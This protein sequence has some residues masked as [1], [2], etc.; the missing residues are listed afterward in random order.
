MPEG[1]KHNSSMSVKQSQA[2]MG[3]PGAFQPAHNQQP[4]RLHPDDMH[5]LVDHIS[6]VAS[7]TYFQ[8]KLIQP[9]WRQLVF[10]ESTGPAIA[11][12]WFGSWSPQSI[13]VYTPSDVTVWAA[14]TGSDPTTNGFPFAGGGVLTRV[15]ISGNRGSLVLGLTEAD[16]AGVPI[17]V[18]L[19]RFPTVD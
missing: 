6:N 17:D 2:K 18:H 3:P 5:K 9:D 13:I 14:A 8:S 12:P 1:K 7:A 19:F 16:F 11:D 10:T 15:P 4:A